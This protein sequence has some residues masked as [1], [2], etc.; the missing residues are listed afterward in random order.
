[1]PAENPP[2]FMVNPQLLQLIFALVGEDRCFHV[3]VVERD[4][5]HVYDKA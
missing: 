3:R 5:A 2:A 4:A 1:M